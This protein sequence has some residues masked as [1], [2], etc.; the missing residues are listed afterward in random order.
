MADVRIPD[1]FVASVVGHV[2]AAS[3]DPNQPWILG[4]EGPPGTG[5]S[6]QARRVLE[7]R[8]FHVVAA[9]GSSL[10][11]GYE[12]DSVKVFDAVWQQ[13]LDASAANPA[14]HPVLV[15]EDFEL[16]P[17]GVRKGVHYTVNSQ[18]LN[19]HLMSLA[20]DPGAVTLATGY[21]VPLL[22]TGND[23]SLLHGPLL[24][25]GRMERF[26]WKPRR[27]ER[28]ELFSSALSRAQIS[29][30]AGLAPRWARRRRLTVADVS[31]AI[32]RCQQ[33]L[34]VDVTRQRGDIDLAAVRDMLS[35]GGSVDSRD[36]NRQLP[37]RISLMR[38]RRR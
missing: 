15:L 27:A 3:C 22:M 29:D 10:S 37:G 28:A 36:V 1:R 35:R 8:G 32:S 20:D 11:G 4:L 6:F 12:R 18:V 31:A 16:S 30:R 33:E 5:K 25:T 26:V 9:S 13:C 24:R 19:G 7:R 14:S 21:R 38:S 2:L 17:A 23:L 34:A